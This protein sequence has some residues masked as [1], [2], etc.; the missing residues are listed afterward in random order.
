[1][2]IDTG[3]ET[4]AGVPHDAVVTHGEML[5]PFEAKETN[6]GRHAGHAHMTCV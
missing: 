2:D 5:R 1:M 6:D 3:L 4:K